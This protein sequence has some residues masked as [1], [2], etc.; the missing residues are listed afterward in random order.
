MFAVFAGVPAGGEGPRPGDAGA[1]GPRQRWQGTP[2]VGEHLEGIAA[3]RPP[4]SACA[5]AAQHSFGSTVAG[6]I[7][8]AQRL[9]VAPWPPRCRIARPTARMYWLVLPQ[10]TASRT[11]SGDTG[12]TTRTAAGPAR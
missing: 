8:E 12:T 7:R 5:V 3:S 2:G 6:G 9:A 10:T 11:A 4:R 1:P